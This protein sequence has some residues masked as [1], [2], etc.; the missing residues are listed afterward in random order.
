VAQPQIPREAR[1]PRLADFL[2]GAIR[3]V[4]ARVEG[5]VQRTPGDGVPVSQP[6]TAYL[7]TTTTTHRLRPVDGEAEPHGHVPRQ[8]VRYRQR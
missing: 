2:E 1:R 5:F 4:E 8:P 3:G 6:T 7:S